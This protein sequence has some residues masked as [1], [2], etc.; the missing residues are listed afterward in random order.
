MLSSASYPHRLSNSCFPPS[1]RITGSSASAFVL[2]H[3]SA[4][5]ENEPHSI[6]KLT[7]TLSNHELFARYEFSRLS[8]SCRQRQHLLES[9]QVLKGRKATFLFLWKPAMPNS[10][11]QPFQTVP[12]VEWTRGTFA[13]SPFCL[14]EN[15]QTQHI[16]LRQT[17]PHYS[18]VHIMAKF[19][20][21]FAI[22]KLSFLLLLPSYSCRLCTRKASSV[23][24]LCSSS[25]LTFSVRWWDRRFS[26]CISWQ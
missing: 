20:A 19:V 8:S 10:N 22:G 18:N 21:V 25:P 1:N 2:L 13:P 26:P 12:K 14:Q 11:V 4:S 6:R 17:S 5:C 3:S 9:A 15:S 16:F 7:T 23:D 24:R